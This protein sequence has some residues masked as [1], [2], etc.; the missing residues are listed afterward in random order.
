[1]LSIKREAP[2]KRTLPAP[3]PM[4]LTVSTCYRFL[5]WM[6]GWPLLLKSAANVQVAATIEPTFPED[7]ERT[8]NEMVLNDMRDMCGTM[9][10]VASRFHAW[11]KPIMFHTVI[12]RR[13]KN[14]LQGISQSL[15][16]NAS[17]I[18][19][20]VLDLPFT[21][22]RGR[23]L[24]FKEA[25]H[26]RRV[27]VA[28]DQVRHLAVTWNIWAQFE[29]KCGA[30]QLE[31][32][33]LIWDRVVD[34][35][36]PSLDRLQHPS[37]LKDLT[38]YAPHRLGEG[39]RK[40]WWRPGAL[41]LPSTAHCANLAYVTYASESKPILDI[42]DFYLRRA[43]FVLV[44]TE[45]KFATAA[46]EYTTARIRR[47]TAKNPNFSVTYLRF[48]SQVLVEWVAKMEG[49]P[50]VLQHPPPLTAGNGVPEG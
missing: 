49:R 11:T 20:L 31:S 28:S 10:L 23:R 2:S 22:R 17:L 41:C 27:L 50:S 48:S 38:V 34:S 29:R 40:S 4:A 6:S 21:E 42:G 12:V 18:R 15:L 37:A 7:I 5:S 26:I 13:Q 45:E 30:L 8:I 19:I 36:D 24:S 46:A 43:R 32:L 9:S 33:Y 39:G 25:S 35:E 3:S 14:W 16:P 1:M 47:D 44:D